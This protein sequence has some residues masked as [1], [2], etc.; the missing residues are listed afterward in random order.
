MVP[1]AVHCGRAVSRVP[2]TFVI[3]SS[4]SIPGETEAYQEVIALLVQQVGKVFPGPQPGLSVKCPFQEQD[5]LRL[6]GRR[7]K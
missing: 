5:L 3:Q 2:G 4:V 6:K 1:E 7:P